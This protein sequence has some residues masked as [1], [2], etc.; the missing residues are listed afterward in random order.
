[1]TEK[2]VATIEQRRSGA[3]VIKMAGVLDEDNPL[4]ELIEKVGTGTALI[5]LSGVERINSTGA[6][7]WV[8]WLAALEQRGIRPVLI[9]CSPAVVAQLNRV[10]NF[11]G[12]A[13]V[14]SFQVPYHCSNC[15]MDKLQLVYIA[16]LGEAPHHAPVC[17][18]DGCGSAMHFVEESDSYFSFVT[19][20][21][22]V[23]A[24][25]RP[26]VREVEQEAERE[27]ARGSISAVTAEQVRRISDPRLVARQSRPSLSVF[28]IPEGKRPSER[29]LTM[30]RKMPG[31][32]P[33]IIAIVMLLLAVV[34]VFVYF[35]V[36]GV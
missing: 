23:K 22:N 29:D 28:Q 15:D 31:G 5:N 11:A 27:L 3:R 8:S 24:P 9:A 34:G 30:P 14:K 4:R 10:R 18:C 35:L 36:Q 25:E 32:E 13:L 1:M 6:R 20:F 17:T 19:H 33:Y 7:D 2:L 26:S 16:D 12:N 21:Q